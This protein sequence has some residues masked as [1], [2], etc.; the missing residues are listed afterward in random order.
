YGFHTANRRTL[1]S[2]AEFL[3]RS[4]DCP[5]LVVGPSVKERPNQMVRL[6][7]F[8]YASALPEETNRSQALVCEL[9]RKSAGHVHIVHAEPPEASVE[10]R[11]HLRSLEMREEKI[12]DSFRRRGV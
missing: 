12:A 4:L 2:T 11:A 3:L 7:N 8:V 6:V 5:V 9:A 10:P 1:G